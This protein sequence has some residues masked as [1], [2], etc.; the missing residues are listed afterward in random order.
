[1]AHRKPAQPAVLIIDDDSGSRE[2]LAEL[3]SDKGYTVET[4]QDGADALAYL[5]SGQRPG[6]I[7][8]DLMMPGTDGWDFR[9]QQKRDPSLAEIPVIAVSAAGRLVDAD[10]SLRKP[11]DID[12]L[13][14]LLRD[15]L[16][17]GT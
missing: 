14:K 10:Y 16:G 6:V 15:V 2:S 11:I 4:A 12:A 9:A 17:A 5:R 13:L 1:M 7:L 3:L 8:L